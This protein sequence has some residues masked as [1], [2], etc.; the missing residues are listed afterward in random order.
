M[1]S[2]SSYRG[3]S[4][5]PVKPVAT[6]ESWTGAAVHALFGDVTDEDFVQAKGLWDVLG[7]TPGQQDNFIGNVSGHLNAAHTDTRNRTYEMFK[8]VDPSLGS[9]IQE[10]TEKLV[11]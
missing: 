7:R 4:Y 6:N 11:K 1:T 5:K 3:L 8:R 2:P 10:A 9:A